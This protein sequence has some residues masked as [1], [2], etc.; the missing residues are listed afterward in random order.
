M[1]G[2]GL[3]VEIKYLA[4]GVEDVQHWT[5]SVLDIE[6]FAALQEWVDLPYR[7]AS[8]VDAAGRHMAFTGQWFS[9]APSMNVICVELQVPG[10]ITTRGAKRV[11][12]TPAPTPLPP[13]DA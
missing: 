4:A 8:V 9:L 5:T 2:L 3:R 6:E 11:Q 1:A 13:E 10:A 7:V 12:S